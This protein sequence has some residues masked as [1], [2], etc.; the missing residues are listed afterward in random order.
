[1]RLENFD[2]N[3]TFPAK[4]VSTT[5]ITDQSTDEVRELV[6]E[7]GHHDFK[8]KV[9]QSIGVIVD[10][11]H[12]ELGFPQHL[13]LYS[14]ADTPHTNGNAKPEVRICVKRA[15]YIDECSGER[16]EGVAS[17]FL[18][19]LSVGE[20][21][22]VCGP[23]GLPF[24]L[25]EDKRCDL[26]LIGMG[27]GIAPFRAFVKHIHQDV[28][29]W[30]GRVYQ[31]YGARSG[32]ETLYLNR[33]Q[34]DFA[35]YCDEETFNAFKALSPRP[36]WSDPIAM[37]YALESR[38]DEILKMLLEKN[39]CIYVAGREEVSVALDHLF[40]SRVGPDKAW[41][42]IKDALEAEERWVELIY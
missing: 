27:T 16:Y 38:S 11:P 23:F 10:G 3:E 20:R 6:L 7:I 17:N 24:S 41:H 36:H 9:G 30:K 1:M 12:G 39:A 15:N 34:D 14:I 31:F 26:I 33:E 22:T 19:D 32:L 42:H 35:E 25:P 5:R 4:V 21:L 40:S 13:R 8:F 29:D 28:K 18:C 37:D 2:V